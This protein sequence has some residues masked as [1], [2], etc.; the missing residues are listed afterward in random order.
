MIPQSQCVFA[1]QPLRPLGMTSLEGRHDFLV[2]DDRA[3]CPVLLDD[4]PLPDGTD[5]EEQVVGDPA[6]QLTLAERDD[7][8]VKADV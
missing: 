1:N 6:D 7:R 5:V 8:L 2:I 3:A 4:R